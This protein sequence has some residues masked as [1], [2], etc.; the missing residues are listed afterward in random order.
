MDIQQ[1]KL[2]GHCIF[3]TE[4]PKQTHNIP[5][6]NTYI[7]QS[8]SHFFDYFET[9]KRQKSLTEK[10]YTPWQNAVK[11]HTRKFS[12]GRFVL[13]LILNPQS[14]EILNLSCIFKYTLNV[15]GFVG[16]SRRTNQFFMDKNYLKVI[17]IHCFSTSR[18]D[19]LRQKRL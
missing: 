17:F 2:K 15:G 4:I 12:L 13:L 16:Y 3:L 11:T 10:I 9:T 1:L 8:S 19:G 6:N 14:T 18:T 7:F 5:A